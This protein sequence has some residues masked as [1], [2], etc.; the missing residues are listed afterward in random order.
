MS[1]Y[2]RGPVFA[3]VDG[4]NVAECKAPGWEVEG[5]VNKFHG[6]RTDCAC[7]FMQRSAGSCRVGFCGVVRNSHKTR[8]FRGGRTRDRTLD[9]SRVKGGR[10]ADYRFDITQL[11]DALVLWWAD[12]GPMGDQHVGRNHDATDAQ[13]GQRRTVRC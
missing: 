10:R 11:S 7:M 4:W 8:G 2:T 12:S 3:I 5:W 6:F 1:P 9:L 13:P